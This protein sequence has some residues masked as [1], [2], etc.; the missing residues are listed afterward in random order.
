MREMEKARKKAE[1]EKEEMANATEE[2]A[3]VM[4]MV[5][6]GATTT[7]TVGN[8]ARTVES[9]KKKKGDKEPAQSE[10]EL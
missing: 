6:Q 7:K 10:D 1:R 5:D 9:R 3:R 8:T 4:R 2:H